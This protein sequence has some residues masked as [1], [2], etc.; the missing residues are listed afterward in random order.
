MSQAISLPDEV[1]MTKIL[2]LRGQ[3]VLIDSDLAF[4]FGVS[5]KRLNEQVRRN[6]RRFPVD[7]MFQLTAEEKSEVVANCDHLRKMKFSRHLP[8]AFTEYGAV[9]LSS[10][11]NSDRAIQVNIQ[12]VR[13]FI[14]LRELALTH[15][16]ILLKLD[17]IESQLSDHDQ[18]IQMIF[19][20]LRQLIQGPPKPRR[21]IGFKSSNSD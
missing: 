1:V 9:M 2:V 3:K 6:I 17:K 10:I 13:I 20:T 16:D 15:K 7:F 12:I 14:K 19:K 21:R 4:L 11:L 18:R 5:T 8:H